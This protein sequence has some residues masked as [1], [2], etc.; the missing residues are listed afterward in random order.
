VCAQIIRR[1]A[2]YVSDHDLGWVFDSN[3]AYKCFDEVNFRRPDVSFIS[4]A[5]K[6]EG[7]VRGPILIAPDLV[8]EVPSPSDHYFDV[9][10]KVR[11]YLDAGVRVV[12][13]VDTE[14]RSIVVDRPGQRPVTLLRDDVFEFPE[15]LPGFSVPATELFTSP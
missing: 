13:T 14:D 10:R 7:L 8:I 15:I 5:R 6:P 9:R 1:L 12:C 3:V 11:L 2:N 4:K